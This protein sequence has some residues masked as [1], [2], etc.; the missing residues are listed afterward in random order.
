MLISELKKDTWQLFFK[1]SNHIN[2]DNNQQ[3]R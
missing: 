2:A 1:F 3:R